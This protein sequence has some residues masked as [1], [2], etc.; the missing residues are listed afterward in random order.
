MDAAS[1]QFDVII[2]GAGPVGL[3]LAIDLGRRGVKTPI[4][5]RNPTTGPWPKMDRTEPQVRGVFDRSVLLLRPDLHIAW[6][7]HAPI[8][9]PAALAGRV[10]GH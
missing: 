1:N 6:S 8:P 9:A 10:T 3:T 5:E 4:M 2:A 7:G